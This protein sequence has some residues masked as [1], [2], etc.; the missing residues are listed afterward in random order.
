MLNSLDDND[1]VVYCPHCLSLAIR[2]IE[3]EDT[4]LDYCDDCGNTNLDT[5]DIETW[6]KM[7][8]EKYGTKYLTYNNK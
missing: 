8:E 7:Y 6:E 2:V 1:L 3:R 4:S 5:I